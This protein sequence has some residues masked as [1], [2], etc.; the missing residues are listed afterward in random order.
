[1]ARTRYKLS[2]SLRV[3]RG[4]TGIIIASDSG[5]FE[6]PVDVQQRLLRFGE[7]L[8]LDAKRLAEGSELS[9]RRWKRL[10]EDLVDAEILVPSLAFGVRGGLSFELSAGM[11]P[12]ER[13]YDRPPVVGIV[14]GSYAARPYVHLQLETRKQLYP[15]VPILVHDDN[16]PER[17]SIEALCEEY[18]AE[19]VSTYCDDGQPLGWHLGDLSVLAAG[20]IW[21]RREGIDLLVKLSRRFVPVRGFVDAL[22]S[23]A[24]ETQHLTFSNVCRGANFSFRT[25]CLA[26]SVRTWADWAPAVIARKIRDELP[27]RPVFLV[28]GFVH[29]IARALASFRCVRARTSEADPRSYVRWDFMGEDKFTPNPNCLWHQASPVS[30][31]V[32]R[33]RA[34]G[35]S[36]TK[37]DFTID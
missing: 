2:P 30:D 20:L 7:G 1:M 22:Q 31:Y 34:L 35:L 18:G 17:S 28:E 36:Y 10:L 23:L 29:E 4:E 9:L 26:V 13:E 24:L 33:A 27:H 12:R 6:V 32:A 8:E 16:S 5:G 37:A 15:G 3:R 11:P 21:A 25:E 19:F 14:L